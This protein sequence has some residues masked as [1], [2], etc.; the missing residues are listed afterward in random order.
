[1]VTCTAPPRRGRRVDVIGQLLHGPVTGLGPSIV[2]AASAGGGTVNGPT[3][4]VVAVVLLVGG[5]VGGYLL[6]RRSMR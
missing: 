3:T 6:R 2:D 4:I 5:V 1:M